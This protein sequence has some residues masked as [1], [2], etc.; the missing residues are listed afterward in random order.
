M[1]LGARVAFNSDEVAGDFTAVAA[2]LGRV[3]GR[4]WCKLRVY[5]RCWH[6]VVAG[7]CVV[8]VVVVIVVGVCVVE[9]L[10]C[11]YF[12]RFL[13]FHIRWRLVFD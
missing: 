8:D 10:R 11:C 7:F 4:C 9:L 2:A 3:A 6:V 1:H 5:C 13:Y 12:W